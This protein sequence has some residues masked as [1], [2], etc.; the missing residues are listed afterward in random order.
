VLLHDK[1]MSLDPLSDEDHPVARDRMAALAF[2]TLTEIDAQGRL[3]PM[4]ASSWRADTAKRVWQFRL[5]LANFTMAQCLPLRCRSQPCQDQ[6]GMEILSA[7]PPDR[8][9][10]KRLLQCSTCRR[11]LAMPR[12]AIVKRQADAS[13]AVIL[14]GTGSYKLSQWQASETRAIYRE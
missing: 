2:E 6:S 12:Y 3:R 13:G 11:L 1:V 5:R 10:L 4:L 9:H 7:G 8:K 14:A